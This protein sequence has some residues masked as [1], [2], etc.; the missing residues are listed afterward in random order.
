LQAQALAAQL[1]PMMGF[2]PEYALSFYK[3]K[4]KLRTVNT[5]SVE[6]LLGGVKNSKSHE[7][8][9]CEFHGAA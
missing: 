7:L 4:K 5:I 6:W 9:A 8:D 1:V 2:W 3:T